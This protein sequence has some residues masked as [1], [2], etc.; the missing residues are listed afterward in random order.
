[1]QEE[2]REREYWRRLADEGLWVPAPRERR[3]GAPVPF[4]PV[5]VSG[6]PLSREII[7][8]RR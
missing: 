8:A 7:E 3:P 6:K 5:E 2:E 4:E 1:M